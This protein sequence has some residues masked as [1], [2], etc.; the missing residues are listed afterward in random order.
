M[1]YLIKIENNHIKCLLLQNM[2]NVYTNM[3]SFIETQEYQNLIK[4]FQAL[5]FDCF[6][7]NDMAW[8]INNIMDKWSIDPRIVKSYSF[9][10]NSDV[11]Y[12][13]MAGSADKDERFIFWNLHLNGITSDITIEELKIVLLERT[14]NV[15]I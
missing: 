2:N 4:K 3:D 12:P 13:S 15:R 14:P 5:V 1:Y 9:N 10:N 6:I 8:E 11:I 7:K